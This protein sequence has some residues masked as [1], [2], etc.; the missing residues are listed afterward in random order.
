MLTVLLLSIVV[1]VYTVVAFNFFRKF[2]I[3]DEDGEIDKKCH[4]MMSCFI[5]HMYVGVRQGG[6]IGDAIEPPDGDPFEVYRILFDI[7]LS[8]VS[9][10]DCHFILIFIFKKYQMQYTY[11]VQYENVNSTENVTHTPNGIA[12]HHSA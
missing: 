4:D 12:V 5:F 7:T 1:Y 6:G 3:V 10:Q 8:K 2:Y 9:L 11:Y